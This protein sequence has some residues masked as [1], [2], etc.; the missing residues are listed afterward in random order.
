VTSAVLVV[1]AV[2]AAGAGATVSSVARDRRLYVQRDR[3]RGLDLTV[4]ATV[5]ARRLYRPG[6]LVVVGGR[7]VRPGWIYAMEASD[8]APRRPA[9]L[10]PRP[11]GA[12]IEPPRIPRSDTVFFVDTGAGEVASAV[13]GRAPR[14]ILLFV[15][16][17]DKAREPADLDDLRLAGWCA[18]VGY[19]F[20]QTG[21]LTVL[22]PCSS[23]TG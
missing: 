13:A 23:R 10:P 2:A 4:D 11:P 14:R 1:V 12:V 18:S 5:A 20:P 19:P 8:D 17:L 3:L 22:D 7:L 21:T 6:D 15:F 9:D 16:D